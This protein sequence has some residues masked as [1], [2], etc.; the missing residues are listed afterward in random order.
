MESDFILPC[1]IINRGTSVGGA[2][3]Q[4][5]MMSLVFRLVYV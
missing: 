4:V 1:Y 5:R 2:D 3:F